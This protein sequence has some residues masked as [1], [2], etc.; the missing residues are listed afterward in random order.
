MTG[1]AGLA[2]RHDPRHIGLGRGGSRGHQ[3]PTASDENVWCDQTF[4]EG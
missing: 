2:T 4:L 3:W 1:G